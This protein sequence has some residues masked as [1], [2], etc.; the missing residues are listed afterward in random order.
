MKE[1]IRRQLWKLLGV[2][3]YHFL[4]NQKRV[5]L[6]DFRE[7]HIGRSTYNNGAVVWR[8]Q[9][10]AGLTIGNYCSIAHGV[11]FFLD[12]GFHDFK[13]VTTFPLFSELYKHHSADYEVCEGL[14]KTFFFEKVTGKKS[15]YIGNDVW[16]GANVLIMPGVCIADGA[17]VLPGSVVSSDIGPYE[18]FGGIPARMVSKRF[19][20]ITI[21]QLLKIKW[22]NW[23]E[24]LIK[25]RIK[26]FYENPAVF[27]A[28]Y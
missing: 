25:E 3:F 17:V 4:K 28:K 6:N 20:E 18:I 11:E 9:R 22:W 12:S 23:E 19:D 27:V 21:Q 1:A 16:L 2:D 10:D 14:T 8:W 5:Y 7:G 13:K 15:I 26:D 24:S